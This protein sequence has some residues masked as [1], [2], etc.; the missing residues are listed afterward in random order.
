MRKKQMM[1]LIYIIIYI[2][3]TLL[4]VSCKTNNQM[5]DA[6]IEN[7]AL[8]ISESFDSTKI[9]IFKKWR[10]FKR[11]TAEVWDKMSG[12]SCIYR[13]VY[14]DKKNTIILKAQEPN[15]F[16]NDF[17]KNIHIDTSFWQIVIIKYKDDLIKLNGV[18][19]YGKDVPLLNNIDSD[20]IFIS[21]SPFKKF[22]ELSDL[23]DSLKFYSVNYYQSLGGLIQFNLS[24]QHI[25]YYIPD[26]ELIDLKFK[27]IWK[28][29]F[30]KG[31]HLKKNWILVKLDEP[32]DN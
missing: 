16:M 24:P 20:S 5:M 30:L 32:I 6:E 15:K 9:E 10:F 12:D 27:Q 3:L 14:L 31:K 21:Q 2:Q 26:I 8:K 22:K 17:N 11:G 28:D 7:N 1:H 4:I 19:R 25:L 13:C 29:K 23:R 18:N